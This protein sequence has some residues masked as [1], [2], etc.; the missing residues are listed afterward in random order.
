RHT[1]FSRDWSS[2]VCSSDM[3]EQGLSVTLNSAKSKMPTKGKTPV[4]IIGRE[5][6]QYAANIDEAYAIAS[7][8][9]SFVAETFLIGSKADGK[10][11]LI[12]KTPE[13]TALYLPDA[14]QMVIT[15]HFQSE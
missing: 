10:V 9:D 1:R 6:L 15:N 12:E 7:S 14:E 8:Y 11:G 13:E 2:D 3:N 5:I 4:S